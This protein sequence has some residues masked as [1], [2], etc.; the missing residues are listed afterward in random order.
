MQISIFKNLIYGKCI[1]YMHAILI[2]DIN[3]FVGF[4]E[5]K[6]NIKVDTHLFILSYEELK[7]LCLLYR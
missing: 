2:E 7:L 5:I 1:S 6:T 4:E 3:I